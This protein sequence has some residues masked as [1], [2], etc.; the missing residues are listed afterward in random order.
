MRYD[1]IKT[2]KQRKAFQ[3]SPKFYVLETIWMDSGWTWIVNVKYGISFHDDGTWG[4]A[5]YS[6]SNPQAEKKYL[7]NNQREAECYKVKIEI[8]E[9]K[10]RIKEMQ[11]EKKYLEIKLKRM[12]NGE[13]EI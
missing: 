5:Y 12:K 7:F 10:Q 1:L 3:S 11:D 4:F 6:S 9:L 2:D 8:D 13:V